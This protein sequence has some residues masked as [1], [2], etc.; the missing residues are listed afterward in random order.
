M[1]L[2]TFFRLP[3]CVEC[4]AFR[5]GSI[6]GWFWLE[7]REVRFSGP[8]RTQQDVISSA[9]TTLVQDLAK[10]I[11]SILR[12]IIGAPDA[13]LQ[14]PPGNRDTFL[15]YNSMMCVSNEWTIG[16]TPVVSHG[17]RCLTFCLTIQR[18]QTSFKFRSVLYFSDSSLRSNA[19]ITLFM[20]AF[21]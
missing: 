19:V 2:L 1:Y 18:L 7:F 17:C 16:I 5:N 9:F 3:T 10:G 12:R 15:L 11:L 14:F 13:E 20:T 6:H 8:V 4:F 21:A